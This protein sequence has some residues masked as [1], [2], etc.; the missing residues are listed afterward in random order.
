MRFGVLKEG[1]EQSAVSSNIN[2][3]VL[4]AAKKVAYLGTSIEEVSL[5]VTLMAQQSGLSSN[6]LLVHRRCWDIT[7]TGQRGLYMSEMED[8]RL[9]WTNDQ[10]HGKSLP[11]HKER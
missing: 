2:Q 5:L 8:A 9:A 3:S 7:P 6:E 1:F 4:T 10:F 11:F